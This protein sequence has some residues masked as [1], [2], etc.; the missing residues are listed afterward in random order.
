[1]TTTHSILHTKLCGL[2][3][4]NPIMLASGIIG[5][6]GAMLKRAAI[7]GIGAVTTK[8]I[9]PKPRMGNLNPSIIELS[10]GTC[11]NAV[12]LANPGFDEF[13]SEMEGARVDGVPIV[14]SLFGDIDEH[15][16]E[17]AVKAE[18]SGFDAVEI[19]ISCPHAEVSSIGADASLTHDVVKLV[20]E[21]IDIP[22]FVKLNPNVT[23][24]VEIA[25][26]AEDAGADAVVAINTIRG[27]AIDIEI[28]KP[29]LFNKSGGVSGKSIKPMA[30][31]AVY[32]LYDNLKIPIIG[33]GG[34]FSG[35]D[36]IEFLLA[37]AT[38]VQV[39]TAFIN[40]LSIIER[41]KKEIVDYCDKHGVLYLNELVGKAH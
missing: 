39:G 34:I 12:G 20:K 15:Y 7:E 31:K 24:I 41:I 16:K 28:Q 30:I 14:M 10:P 5:T 1:M 33:C 21:A 11:L 8:S 27:M 13:T 38:A 25:R 18:K 35:N 9:G 2:N 26:S 36:V 37:G 40:G 22:L 3:L 19:N 6:S 29:I 32:D 17:L 23:S 4:S